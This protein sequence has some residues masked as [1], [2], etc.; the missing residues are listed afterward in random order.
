MN[1][2]KLPILSRAC[3]GLLRFTGGFQERFGDKAPAITFNLFQRFTQNDWGTICEED[4][5]ANARY[6]EFH[7]LLDGRFVDAFRL[8]GSYEVEGETVWVISYVSH[9]PSKQLNPDVCNTCVLLPS[10]Y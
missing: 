5:E 10:E 9:K 6:M 3:F 4:K 1:S 7:L 8:M 2:T